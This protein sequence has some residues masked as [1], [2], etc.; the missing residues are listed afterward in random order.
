MK[1]RVM[2]AAVWMS[3]GM[4]MAGEAPVDDTLDFLVSKAKSAPATRPS[5]T[6]PVSPFAEKQN[7]PEARKGVVVLSN[8]EKIAGQV[9]T[10]REKPLRLWDE[11][12]KE[13][14]DIPWNLIKVAEA[15]IVWERD[16]K[17]WHFRESGSDIKE[18]TGKTYP[19]RELEYVVTLVNDQKITGGVVAPVYVSAGEQW[20]MVALNKRQKGEVGKGLKELVY[21]RRIELE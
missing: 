10:T 13:Y 16:E 5:T 14:R 8:G 20:V 6:R 4:L 19:A 21:V 9:S 18:Y 2:V 17:E 15:K 1:M 7:D 11:T 3:G 12:A